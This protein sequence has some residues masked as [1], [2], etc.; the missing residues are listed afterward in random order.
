MTKPANQ[1][2]KSKT[3]AKIEILNKTDVTL[4]SLDK[5]VGTLLS[6]LAM[7]SF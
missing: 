3:S 2:R 4:L 1:K 7:N 6:N 5:Y